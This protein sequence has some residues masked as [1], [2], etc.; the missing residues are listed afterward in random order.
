MKNGTRMKRIVGSNHELTE[1]KSEE[2]KLK[3]KIW[4]EKI[5]EEVQV[6]ARHI[7]EAKEQNS[8][9]KFGLDINFI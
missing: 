6:N 2:D 9:I 7:R 8:K 5:E 1:I 3:L 4:N